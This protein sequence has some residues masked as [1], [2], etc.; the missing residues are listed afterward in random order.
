MFQRILIP[1][2]F[3][4]GAERALTLA[5]TQFQGARL[6]LLHVLDSRAMA[7]PDLTTGGM[8]PVLPPPD[9]QRELGRV[10]ESRLA[11][12]VQDGE[13]YELLSGDPVRGILQAARAW[14]AD[15]IVMGTHGRRGLAHFFLGSVAE[16]VVR[17]SPVPVLTVRDSTPDT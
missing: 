16:Q 14:N 6:K 10:D 8:A 2:D 4:P 11:R 17:E 1:T 13:E 7:V 5:R 9:V 12:E 15:L 3:S